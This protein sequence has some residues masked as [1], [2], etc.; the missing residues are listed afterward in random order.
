MYDLAVIAI[1]WCHTKEDGLNSELLYEL[2]KIYNFKKPITSDGL[3]LFK[4]FMVFAAL[5]FWLSRLTGHMESR[6]R[7]K[8]ANE[9]RAILELLI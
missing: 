6:E 4:D 5:H 7:S 2:L 9:I 1:D 8:N 3:W